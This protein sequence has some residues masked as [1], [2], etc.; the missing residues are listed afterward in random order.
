[1]E[2]SGNNTVCTDELKREYLKSLTLLYV[3]DDESTRNQFSMFFKHLAGTIITETNG[4]DGL[5]AY[6]KHRPDI[7]VTDIWMPVM[8]GL[9]MVGEIR[10]TD[11]AVSII[12][13]SAFVDTEYLQK[14]INLGI[15]AYLTKPVNSKHL[16]KTLLDQAHLLRVEAELQMVWKTLQAEHEK[17]IHELRAVR[18]NVTN[19][20]C[21]NCP[22]MTSVVPSAVV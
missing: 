18:Q 14:S 1:M 5:I 16:E 4:A 19:I 6:R 9:Q 7:I 17:N 2:L 8:D 13:L 11:K 15:N 20:S 21:Y 22:C 3:E 12:M 10:P